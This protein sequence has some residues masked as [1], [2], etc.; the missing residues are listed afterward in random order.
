MDISCIIMILS[1]L[2]ALIVSIAAGDYWLSGFMLL[3]MWGAYESYRYKNNE[4]LWALRCF[5][6]YKFIV[7]KKIIYLDQNYL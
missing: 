4:G 1:L 5:L 7:W 6:L 3:V 2:S